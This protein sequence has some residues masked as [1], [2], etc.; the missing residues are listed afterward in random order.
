MTSQQKSLTSDYKYE[1]IFRGSCPTCGVFQIYKQARCQR[2]GCL[3]LH[4]YSD[5]NCRCGQILWKGNY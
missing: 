3:V 1:E 2:M 4:C 5:I